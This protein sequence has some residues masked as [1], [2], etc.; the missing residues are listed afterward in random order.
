MTTA[1]NWTDEDTAKAQAAWAEYQRQHDLS[2]K[3]GQAVGIDPRSG[4][5]WFGG[6]GLDAIG[7]ARADGVTTPLLLLRVGYPYYQRKGGRR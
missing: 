2:T 5:V 7:A 3:H 6:H 4:R 1:E